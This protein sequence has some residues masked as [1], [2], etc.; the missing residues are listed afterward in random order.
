MRYAPVYAEDKEADKIEKIPDK[1]KCEMT[2]SI[3][4]RNS[5]TLQ[6]A[7]FTISRN[8]A[9]TDY[10]SDVF[11]IVVISKASSW[12]D[13]DEIENQ[14]YALAVTIEHFGAPIDIY[15][16]V[17]LSVRQRQRARVAG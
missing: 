2:P 12:L 10:D 4:R 13:T 15:N 6:K 3:T 17:Q 16:T 9:L 11:H 14:R 7:T 8:Q 5:G 1:Y